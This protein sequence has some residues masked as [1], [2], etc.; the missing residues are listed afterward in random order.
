MTHVDLFSGIGGFALAAKWADIETK[1]FCE[2]DE[3]CKRVLKKHWPC[4]PIHNDIHD[5]KYNKH[6][7][8]L[9]GGFPCQPFSIAGK[10]KGKNDDRYLWPEMFRVI[11]QCKPTWVIAENVVGIIEMELENIINDLENEGYETQSFVIPACA[12]GA[13]HKRDR[14]WIV[15]NL[16]SIGSKMREHNRQERYIQENE[17]RNMAKIQQEWAQF[18]P[19]TWSSMSARDWLQYNCEFSRNDD[20]I[21]YR[22]DRIKSLG[23]AI[24]PQI[25]FVFFSLIRTIQ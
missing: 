7:D 12:V 2:K 25:A 19:N 14:L 18:I 1:I 17:N 6:I 10:R 22:M 24:V 15:A 5:F 23:N 3:F 9:T 16:N 20:G 8:V 21:S 4:V 11:R 13:P